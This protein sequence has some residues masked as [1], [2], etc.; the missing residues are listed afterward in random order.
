MMMQKRVEMYEVKT[1]CIVLVRC[2]SYT[3]LHPTTD[4][5]GD[6]VSRTT[7]RGNTE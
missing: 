6:F 7:N 1:W 2:E 4:T 5:L 3:A